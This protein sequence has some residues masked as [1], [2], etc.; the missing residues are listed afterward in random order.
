[1]LFGF[2]A[3]VISFLFWPL[4]QVMAWVTAL[5]L[6]YVVF[7]AE[8]FGSAHYAAIDIAISLRLAV[9][10]YLILGIIVY[11]SKF[12]SNKIID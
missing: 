5:G 12:D 6:R 11:V 3:V 1:M 2:L 7:I 4:A 8:F 9:V 10:C